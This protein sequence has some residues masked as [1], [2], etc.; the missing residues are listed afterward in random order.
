M[1]LDC[2][3]ENHELAQ[4]RVIH[5]LCAMTFLEFVVLSHQGESLTS[6]ICH[7][8][9]HCY[10]RGKGTW[11]EDRA[12]EEANARATQAAWGMPARELGGKKDDWLALACEWRRRNPHRKHLAETKLLLG[13]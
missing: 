11:S 12:Q 2:S 13:K 10:H 9:A 5:D 8:L 4:G 6:V 7:E 3:I 1:D